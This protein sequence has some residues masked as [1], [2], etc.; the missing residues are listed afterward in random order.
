VILYSGKVR[1]FNKYHWP[2]E[3]NLVITQFH[4]YNFKR[5]SKEWVSNSR[6]KAGDSYQN[7]RRRDEESQP[8]FVRVRVPRQG[9]ARLPNEIK[10]VSRVLTTAS[11]KSSS[12]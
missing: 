4:I 2:Q 1:K 5:K 11:N 9:R 12:T 8:H 6:A 7:F 10:G 3:R